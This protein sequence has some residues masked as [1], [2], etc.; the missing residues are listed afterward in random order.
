MKG[1][2][3][4]CVFILYVVNKLLNVLLTGQSDLQFSQLF[5]NVPRLWIIN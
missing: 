4:F 2:S 3:F 5:L 1:T